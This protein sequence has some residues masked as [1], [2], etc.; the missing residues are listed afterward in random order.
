[1]SQH[2]FSA[3]KSPRKEIGYLSLGWDVDKCL[4]GFIEGLKAGRISTRVLEAHQ[5]PREWLVDLQVYEESI[6][7]QLKKS[8]DYSRILREEVA[9][10]DKLVA[11]SVS[12]NLTKLTAHQIDC[13]MRHAA[14]LT[15]IQVRLYCPSL[16][17]H[18]A[19]ADE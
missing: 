19:E 7:E 5:I 9:D 2:L 10:Q 16:V 8:I 17:Y 18:L 11:R 15:D 14:S 4:S 6:L 3:E 13:L 12:T 1:M